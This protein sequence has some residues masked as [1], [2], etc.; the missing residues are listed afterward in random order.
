MKRS[1][2]YGKIVDGVYKVF[3]PGKDLGFLIYF[4]VPLIKNGINISII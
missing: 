1:N 3:G 2:N 4:K